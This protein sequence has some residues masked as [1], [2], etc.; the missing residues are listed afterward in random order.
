MYKYYTIDTTDQARA[1][2]H[3]RTSVLLVLSL[4]LYLPKRKRIE[5]LITGGGAAK[6][7]RLL[8]ALVNKCLSRPSLYIQFY[9][10]MKNVL[11]W[12]MII[13]V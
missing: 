9:A 6:T 5:P 2:L 1:G 8:A 13:V 10:L 12:I 7:I 4:I 3:Y 11:L